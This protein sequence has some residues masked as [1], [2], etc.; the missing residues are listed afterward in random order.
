MNFVPI[1]LDEY[2]HYKGSLT[3]GT[4]DQAVNWIV[5]RNPL[6]IASNDYFYALKTIKGL[7]GKVVKTSL[8][9]WRGPEQ[10]ESDKE[11]QELDGSFWDWTSRAQ[12]LAAAALSRL[13]NSR[14]TLGG[15]EATCR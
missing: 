1:V 2:F 9:P 13:S 6:A 12:L 14:P 7:D 8:L 15:E 5:F 10:R 11:R 3:T 4:C